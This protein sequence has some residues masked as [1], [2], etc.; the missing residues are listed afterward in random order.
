[1]IT[2]LE[3]KLLDT[4]HIGSSSFSVKTILWVREYYKQFANEK[5]ETRYIRQQPNT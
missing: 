3:V 1:M 4:Y 5:Y 2:L